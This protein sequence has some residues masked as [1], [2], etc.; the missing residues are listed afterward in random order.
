[1][2]TSLA[3]RQ[4]H[5]RNGTGPRSGGS[6]T[7]RGFLV[8]LPLVLF[9][10]F[11][12]AA[13]LGLVVAVGAYGY[14]SQGLPDP[15]E[16]LSSLTFA[17]QTVIYDST[18]KVELARFGSEK[19]EV[20]DYKDIPPVLIDATTSIE[21]KTF[22]TNAGFDPLAIV[23]AGIDTISGNER[24]ASTITQQLVRERLLPQDVLAGSKYDR[25]IKEIIQS[26]RLTQEFGPGLEGKQQI[27]AAYLNQNFYG[28]QS[29]GIKAAAKSYFGIDDL[30]KLTV[31]QA[32]LLA[33]IP[34]SPTAY[35]LVKNA[36]DECTVPV[37]EGKTCPAA[38]VQ[39]VVPANSAVVL[40]R[41]QILNAMLVNRVLTAA[42]TPA[43]VTDT[44]ITAA[45]D[46]PAVLASQQPPNW[47]APH[48]VWQ[49]R[50]DLTKILCGDTAVT[51]DL[52]DRGGYQVT[53]TLNWTMQKSAE[54]WVKA[55]VIGP[56]QKST[57]TYLKRLGISDQ[58]W[59]ENLRGKNI[60]NGALI[61]IDYR[62]GRI[63]AY[64]GSA[65]YYGSSTKTF[66]P[67]YDVLA[68]GWRQPG[69]AF[70]PINYITGI[71]NGTLTAASLFMDTVT[72]FGGGYTP[73]DADLLERG[74]VRL[75][76]ALQF[77]LNIP[78]VKAAAETG[79]DRIFD[80]AKRFGIRFQASQNVAGDSIGIGTLEVHPEDLV[81]AYGAIADGGVLMPR[82][83]IVSV[84]GPDGKQVWPV[85][86]APAPAGTQVV[87][88]QSAFI[89][90]DIL[91][92][93]TDPHQN[94]YWGKNA[95]VDKGTRRPAT[96]KTGTTNDTKDLSAYGFLAP[97]SDPTGSR[98]RGRGVDGQQRQLAD[99]RGVLARIDGAALAGL[100]VRG[101]RGH[102]DRRLPEAA[103]HRPG[104]HRRLQRHGPRAVR[105]EDHERVL[106]RRDAAHPDRHDEGGGRH[107][108]GD[109]SPLAGRL[110]RTEA[111]A[112]LP[113]P[114]GRRERLGRLEA[115]PRR[116]DRPR[117]RRVR[118]RRAAR[119]DRD[120]LLL[121]VGLPA[122]RGDVGGSVRADR[123]VHARARDVATTIL[124]PAARAVSEPGGDAAAHAR[125]GGRGRAGPSLPRHRRRARSADELGPA[126][127]R[128]PAG[129][130]TAGR[131]RRRP[132]TG[133]GNPGAV[134]HDG[135]CHA[136]RGE[137]VRL[138]V[139]PESSQSS[140]SSG[141]W[142]ATRRRRMA[143]GARARTS[144]S[145]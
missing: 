102:A 34:Q 97:P 63:L 48:F 74:P 139:V 77:S 101:E 91:A 5:R 103:G 136:A 100:P 50:D 29:Y 4:R 46:E 99:E 60:H 40:R 127:G 126:A 143:S 19:R 11:I 106:H 98:D 123:H 95:I 6:G 54:K 78:A 24:G 57:S 38:K 1:M 17:Q 107:R 89:M 105:D 115:V 117:R 138:R 69:S 64:V 73:T 124:R 80:E 140:E 7:T 31:A 13:L 86:D 49:V 84:T 39:L 20:V 15:L 28:N 90:T 16:Q 81:S 65:D 137:Q 110:P 109:G 119:E 41:N 52:L 59:I 3:R 10:S 45:K 18:G 37:A 113:R 108:L 75:R 93:N 132:G 43:E 121:R 96:L 25:K 118:G 85:A 23:K 26:I 92:G 2:Q 32:A 33:A 129:Q 133:T 27:I 130:P 122:V 70:K 87:S 71:Q 9:F 51:C 67:K 82:Q 83:T 145:E 61:A 134:R 112:R 116:L 21:D 131:A 142:R 58:P 88:A 14:Y 104:A 72:D 8:A 76:E 135:E 141:R 12:L 53:T 66:Q 42:G 35:D 125:A 62:T 68:D 44:Q 36:V 47:K 94:P 120:G 56:N 79:P 111:D 22:W 144:E 55:S 128:R 114:V 30:S